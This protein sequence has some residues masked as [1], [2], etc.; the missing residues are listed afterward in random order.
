MSH[1]ILQHKL[2]NCGVSGCLPNWCRD[3][4]SNR[5]QRVVLVVLLGYYHWSK[6]APTGVLSPQG[7]QGSSV[8]PLFSVMFIIDLPDVVSPTSLVTLCACR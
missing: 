1:V 4:L 7:Y 6:L 5:K 8:R 2:C 3:Y